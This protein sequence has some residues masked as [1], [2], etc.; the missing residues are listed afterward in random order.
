MLKPSQQL[1]SS[2]VLIH[3]DPSLPITL[4]GDASA[5]GIGSVISHV[6]P[7]GSER[8]IAFASRTLSPTKATQTDPCLSKILQ[9]V[10]QGWP[11]TVPESLRP[12]QM[13]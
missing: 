7:D 6:L 3:Y 2:Q 12:C 5:Y 4:A 9:Y 11:T 10:K 8:P 1:K 13:N